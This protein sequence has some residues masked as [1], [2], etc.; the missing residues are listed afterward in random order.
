MRRYYFIFLLAPAFLLA[1]SKEEDSSIDTDVSYFTWER[2]DISPEVASNWSD[3]RLL[4]L[5]E[6][7]DYYFRARSW[8][9]GASHV[10]KHN[11][12]SNNLQ[13]YEHPMVTFQDSWHE[14]GKLFDTGSRVYNIS[15][16]SYL[17]K[18][19]GEWIDIEAD[20]VTTRQLNY[21]SYPVLVDNLIYVPGGVEFEAPSNKM[22]RYSLQEESWLDPIEMPISLIA[23]LTLSHDGKI[24]IFP[25]GITL[26]HSEESFQFIV[27]DIEL[28]SWEIVNGELPEGVRSASVKNGDSF[29]IA[30]KRAIFVFNPGDY[31]FNEYAR[32]P[33]VNVFEDDDMYFHNLGN[34]HSWNGELHITGTKNR[35]NVNWMAPDEQFYLKLV[36]KDN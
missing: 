23:A 8:G 32:F 16:P 10:I 22:L 4:A 1:C 26:F 36:N 30:F 3:L 27:Y 7:G 13:V 29:Y 6:D 14:S 21:M 19:S 20:E 34:L 9:E 15:G 28:D 31:S 17:D 12:E 24:F 11:R 33:N 2:V 18:A 5:T 25:D 35:I